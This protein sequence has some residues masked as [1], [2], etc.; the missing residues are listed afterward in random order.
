MHGSLRERLPYVIHCMNAWLQAMGLDSIKPLLT[1]LLLPPVPWLLMILW[2]AW[3]LSRRR[4]LGWPLLLLGLTMIWACSTSV[5]A[6]ALTRALLHPPQALRDPRVLTAKGQPANS[7]VIIVLGG[8]RK[9]SA[10]YPEVSLSDLSMERLRYGIWLSRETALPVAFSGG[11]SPW[12][13][14]GPSEGEIAA[15]VAREE[16]RHPLRWSE[17][18]SRDTHENALRTVEILKT[19]NFSR[20]VLVTHDMHM[21]RALRNFERAREAAGMNFTLVPAPVGITE[22]AGHRLL[23]DFVPSPDGIARSR[24]AIREW[25]GLLAGA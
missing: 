20:V 13:L 16:Y 12:S 2:G 19:Q 4:I 10:E 5:M 8:G 18:R 1:A 25:L 22:R 11:L 15:R 3:R 24:Y 14:G 17:D 23:G 9:A 6:D 21:P 7:T